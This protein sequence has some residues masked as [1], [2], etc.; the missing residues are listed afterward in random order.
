[1]LLESELRDEMVVWLKMVKDPKLCLPTHASI[2]LHCTL[3][4]GTNE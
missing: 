4:E 2:S 1:M 3:M